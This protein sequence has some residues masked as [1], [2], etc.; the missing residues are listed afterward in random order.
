MA[1]ID[2]PMD[3][4]LATYCSE[5]APP[6]GRDERPPPIEYTEPTV[7]ALAVLARR[8]GPVAR[9]R[10]KANPV[11]VDAD[12]VERAAALRETLVAWA[13]EETPPALRGQRL[14]RLEYAAVMNGV[15]VR[16]LNDWRS[17]MRA[18]YPRSYGFKDLE[19]DPAVAETFERHMRESEEW[20]RRNVAE[21]RLRSVL[22]ALRAAHEAGAPTILYVD[23]LHR[24]LGGGG[25]DYP[26]DLAPELKPL[27][28]RGQIHLW[29][30][31]SLAEYR[32]TI[33]H[34]STMQ[35]CFQEIWLPGAPSA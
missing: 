17:Q 32:V 27:L 34:D 24:L 4:P 15:D 13:R 30:A 35:R 6:P 31:C 8:C 33:E 12:G 29:G 5:L 25:E 26:I 1:S 3:A 10:K 19:C 28:H 23:H 9:E 18:R 21:Q 2:S 16:A 20:R 14:L 22:C 7:R 11:W